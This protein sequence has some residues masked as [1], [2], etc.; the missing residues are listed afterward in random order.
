MFCNILRRDNN[1]TPGEIGRRLKSLRLERGY[2]QSKLAQMIGFKDRQ[3]VSAIETGVRHMTVDEL[4]LFAERLEFPLEY[5]TDPFLLVGEGQ[6]S[7][8]QTVVDKAHLREFEQ[9]MGCCIAAYRTLAHEFGR[10]FTNLRRV[11]PLTNKSTFED[12]MLAGERF[13]EEFKLGETPAIQLIDVM[14]QKLGFLVLMVDAIEG[15][16]GAACHLK[17]LDT[18]L[19]ARK[20]VEGRRNF[21]LAHELF[22]LLTWESMAPDHQEVVLEDHKSRIEQLA[23]NF[24]AAVLMP[25]KLLEKYDSWQTSDLSALTNRLNSVAN[26]LHVTSSALRWRLV[27]LDK[28]NSSL[29]HALPESALRNNGDAI[30]K[31][32]DPKLFSKQFA[33]IIG[34]AIATGRVSVWRI[35]LLLDLTFEELADFFVSHGVDYENVL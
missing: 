1:L 19:I 15:V 9:K 12:A 11:L 24:A 18:I 28:L 21:D 26:E 20:E 6:F 14:E 22:H 33:E 31:E 13:V 16:S 23:N 35:S 8:R 2:S 30:E 10:E 7:W 27:A 4:L 25:R 32:K 17:E 5:F 3:T 34:L 29:A